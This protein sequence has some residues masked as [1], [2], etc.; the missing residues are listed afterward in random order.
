VETKGQQRVF[1]VQVYLDDLDSKAVKV[2]L[3]A[4]AVNGGNP[5][6]QEM[7]LVRPLVGATG[8]YDYSATVS[9]ARPQS[10][11][12]ARVIPHSDGVV[13]PLEEARILWQ[14]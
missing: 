3:Y 14:R 2:E 6:R 10:D 9:V 13:I 1:N 11:Y 5:E 12:T 4:N 7:K 8:G